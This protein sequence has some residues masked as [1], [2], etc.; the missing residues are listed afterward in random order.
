MRNSSQQEIWY[1][2]F[3]RWRSSAE[4]QVLQVPDLRLG[5]GADRARIREMMLDPR[6]KMREG[7]CVKR[8]QFLS[9]LRRWCRKNDIADFRVVAERGAGSHVKVYANGR[10]T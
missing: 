10:E 3:R 2:P 8:E 6:I 1:I 7:V 5:Q 4:D 9:G